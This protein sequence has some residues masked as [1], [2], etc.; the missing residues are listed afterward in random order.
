MPTCDWPTRID[1][2]LA[3]ASQAL[4]AV[5]DS[6]QLDAQLLL[7]HCLQKPRSY[8]FTWPEHTV[9]EE[10]LACFT[11]LLAH[12][13]Q[14]R[15]IAHLLGEREF[16]GL[17]LK[18]TPDTLIPRPDT[19]VL[20]EAA[21]EK[22]AEITTPCHLLDLGTG[23]GA[24]ALALKHEC[25]ACRVTALDASSAALAVAQDNAKRLQLDVS[26]RLSDWFAA[27]DKNAG[28]DLIVSNPPYIEEHD[29][30]LQQGDVRFDPLSALTSGADGLND[31]RIIIDQ[32]WSFLKPD[33]W[34]L[35]EHGYDQATAVQQLFVSRGYQRVDTRSDYQRNPRVTLGQKPA[36]ATADTGHTPHP[37]AQ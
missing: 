36:E 3:Q 34:L 12:R 10:Q 20:V 28:F 18:V 19:E 9:S 37:T 25:P 30:H 2:L 27:L 17:A 11:Q 15:P 5:S 21:L 31:L 22:L 14:G 23:S 32:A 35:V 26:F 16:W 1:A 29:P 33:G 4:E 7:A 13:V 6:A 24:I 8:L